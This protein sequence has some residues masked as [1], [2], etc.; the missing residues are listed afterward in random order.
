MAQGARQVPFEDVG[1][2]LSGLAS[3]DRLNEVFIVI[4]A[5]LERLDHLSLGREGGRF[6]VA[7]N[8]QVAIGAVKDVADLGPQEILGGQTAD[9]E[10]QLAVAVIE[11]A[12]LRVGGFAI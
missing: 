2:Q 1:V 12:N 6:P 10:D 9:L 3:T 11:D 4:P 5:V 8:D 7:V